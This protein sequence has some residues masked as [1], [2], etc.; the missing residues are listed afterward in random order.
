MLLIG[1]TGSI[2]TGKSTVANILSSPPHSLPLIDADLLARE[3]VRPGTRAYASIAKHFGPTTPD[4]LLPP[5]SDSSTS[6][7]ERTDPPK[8]RGRPL[9]RAAL[10]RR[11]FGP[12]PSRVRDRHALNAIVHPAVRLLMLRAILAH[13]ARGRSWAVVLDIPLLFE[14]GLDVFCG[15]VVVVGVSSPEVQMQRLRA[16]DTGLSAEEARERVGSQMSVAEK[17]DRCRERG[18]SAGRV[19]WN[20]EGKEELQVEV[21][22]V[23]EGLEHGRGW[24]W[25]W[26][27]WASPFMAAGWALW[28]V[29]NGWRARR[30]WEQSE[31]ESG[32]KE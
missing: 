30:R 7:A 11:V 23:M 4:L 29:W 9:N 2:A 5:A 24:Y 21:A 26:W 8:E 1:L 14:S 31:K 3:A 17:V 32:K 12:T 10:G 16:R 18:A 25:R 13:Y 15:A 19:V 20:D 27:L 28:A 22:R 6:L